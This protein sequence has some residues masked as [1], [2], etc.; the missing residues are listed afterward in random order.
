MLDL[1]PEDLAARILDLPLE[2]AVV[3]FDAD[4]TLW[5]TDAGI[6][7]LEHASRDRLLLGE[8]GGAGVFDAYVET[9]AQDEGRGLEACALGFVGLTEARV[10]ELAADYA[11]REVIPHIYPAMRQLFDW[12]HGVGARVFVVTASF[13]H[14]ARAAAGAMGVPPERVIG[15]RLAVDEEGVVTDRFVG[16]ITYRGGKPAALRAVSG[17]APVLAMGNGSNDRELLEAATHLAV[18]VNPS[19]KTRRDGTISL[20]GRAE[21]LGWPVLE[22]ADPSS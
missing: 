6:G 16:P 19:A 7:L 11:A 20:A 12:M 1:W 10:A 14:A 5:H 3:A 18:A 8:D 15:I 4:E 17:A 13:E 9:R 21:E 22:L 2:G